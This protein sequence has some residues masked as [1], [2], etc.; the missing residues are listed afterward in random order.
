MKFKVNGNLPT[1]IIEANNET[2]AIEKY[3][4][5]T[6]SFPIKVKEVEQDG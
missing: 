6:E 4:K 2:E 3:I 5:E 1:L